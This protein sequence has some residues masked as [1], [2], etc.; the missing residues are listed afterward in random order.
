MK[1]KIKAE[2]LSKEEID[3]W[4]ESTDILSEQLDDLMENLK[5]L[6]NALKSDNFQESSKATVVALSIKSCLTEYDIHFEFITRDM[7][8]K[9]ILKII[10]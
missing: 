6:K 1:V 2:E 5:K 10:K 8:K 9:G 4:K 3:N 7:E